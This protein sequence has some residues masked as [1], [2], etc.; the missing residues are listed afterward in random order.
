MI[1]CP[2]EVIQRNEVLDETHDSRDPGH[3]LPASADVQPSH[4]RA[5]ALLT[6]ARHQVEQ[7]L[8]L[9]LAQEAAGEAHAG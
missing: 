3:P 2:Q 9:L 6:T 1:W 5:V 8:V 7:I 4:G